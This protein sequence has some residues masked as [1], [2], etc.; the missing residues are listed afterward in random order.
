MTADMDWPLWGWS[1]DVRPA[2]AEAVAA[3]RAAALVTL[4]RTVGPAPRPAGSQM[5]VTEGGVSGFLSGGCVEGDLVIHAR[6]VLADGAPRTL[7]YGEGSP[8]WDIRLLCGARIEVLVE[9]VAPDSPAIGRLLALRRERRPA[10]WRTDGVNQTCSEAEAE[11]PLLSVASEPL[12]LARRHDP[13][14]RLAVVG[15][16]P[17]ALAIAALGARSGFETTLI[18]PNGPEAAPPLPGVAYSRAEPARAL[19]SVGLDP[20]TA[21]AVATHDLE[22]DEAALGAAV[23]SPAGYVGVLGARKRLPERLDRLR[24]LGVPDEALVRLR[25]PIGLPIGG[26]AP[27]EIAVSVMGEIMQTAR[28]RTGPPS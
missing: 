23:P 7:V 17:T 25:A 4:F 15:G 28:A 21:V 3:G 18:R 12:A 1:D 9:R 5:L 24:A 11:A 27:W 14:W 8:F 13:A 6:S 22:I 16:D 2:L 26:K 20:W 10:M 19:A